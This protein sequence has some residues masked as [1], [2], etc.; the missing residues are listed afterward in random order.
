MPQDNSS[1]SPRTSTPVLPNAQPVNTT[2]CDGFL[3]TLV[4]GT[5]Y[6][7]EHEDDWGDAISL[8]TE[9]HGIWRGHAITPTENGKPLGSYSPHT[10]ASMRIDR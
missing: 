10:I 2:R 1:L 3:V 5:S 4:C 9:G 7:Y 6:R 8:Y